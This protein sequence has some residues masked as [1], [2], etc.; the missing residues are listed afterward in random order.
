[1]IVIPMTL[2]STKTGKATILRTVTI[3]NDGKGTRLRGNYK[4]TL[5]GKKGR[6]LREA[7]IENWPRQ[8]KTPEA[9]LLKALELLDIR[10]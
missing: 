10:R 6:I 8:S 3:V 5:K 7:K 1:M 9:L 2:V 4:V